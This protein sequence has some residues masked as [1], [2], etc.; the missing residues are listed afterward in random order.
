MRDARRALRELGA[1][2]HAGKVVLEVRP[3]AAA[4]TAAAAS[5]SPPPPLRPSRTRFPSWVVTGGLGALGGLTARWLCASQGAQRIVLASRDAHG[6]GEED[7]AASAAARGELEADVSV[8]RCDAASTSDVAA[9]LEPLLRRAGISG[10]LA[11]LIH[12]GGALADAPS[13]LARPAALRAAAAA[14]A[15]AARAFAA[16]L[17][18]EPLL[19]ENGTIAFAS[20]AALLGAPGQAAY[21]AANGAM[22]SVSGGGECGGRG[23]R[24]LSLQWGGWS[25]G[26]AASANSSSAAAAIA[27][28]MR[29]N[30]MTPLGAEMGLSALAA[31]M[32]G[33]LLV[34][35]E[36]EGKTSSTF[37]AAVVDWPLLLKGKGAPP[38]FFSDLVE[39]PEEATTPSLQQQQLAADPAKEEKK[40]KKERRSKDRIERAAA[41]AAAAVVAAAAPSPPAPVLP[42]PAAQE[43]DQLLLPDS[44]LPE[45]LRIAREVL[46][47]AVAAASLAGGNPATTPLSEAGLDSLAAVELRNALAAAFDLPGLSPTVAY[48]APTCAE[49]AEHVCRMLRAAGRGWEAGDAVEVE[50]EVVEAESVAASA[51][52]AAAAVA[53]AVAPLPLPVKAPT[54]PALSSS[55][56]DEEEEEKRGR[57][58]QGGALLPSA[59]GHGQRERRRRR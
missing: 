25:L 20:T 42:P 5:S 30:G 51:I 15:P 29:R 37:A 8:A 10:G 26:M 13:A 12:S 49:L 28:R 27:A 22:E 54:S 57:R 14:K 35:E 52:A 58:G 48:D 55:S 53:P 1:A 38:P 33:P 31:A 3:A 36:E 59:K 43:K 21:A 56:S 2:K 47:P 19:S 6:L 9:L 7:G 23:E 45:V 32:R 39:A 16:R 18:A 50:V 34:G 24:A 11:G 4:A 46:G 17:A 41:T 40:K 44:V